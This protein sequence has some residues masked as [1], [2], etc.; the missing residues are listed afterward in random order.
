MRMPRRPNKI[1]NNGSML[2]IVENVDYVEKVIAG[3]IIHLHDE[4]RGIRW[5]KCLTEKCEIVY[6]TTDTIKNS[7]K[8]ICT[9]Y[10]A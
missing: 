7:C 3:E 2:L 9:L 8:L 6:L 5:L 10:D 4:H 1:V